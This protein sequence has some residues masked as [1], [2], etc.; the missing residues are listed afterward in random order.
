M[1]KS[2]NFGEKLSRSS[3][4]LPRVI[5]IWLQDPGVA[6]LW[7]VGCMAGGMTWEAEGLCGLSGGELPDLVRVHQ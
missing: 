5:G 7:S 3:V 2:E 6:S 1:R 4:Y